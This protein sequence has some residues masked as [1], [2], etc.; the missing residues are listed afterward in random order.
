MIILK[1]AQTVN[2]FYTSWLTFGDIC[3]RIIFGSYALHTDPK[4]EANLVCQ[5][6]CVS[7]WGRDDTWQISE[8]TGSLGTSCFKL[9]R[10]PLLPARCSRS[11]IFSKLCSVSK[12]LHRSVYD[13]LSFI[14]NRKL[15]A[16]L[17]LVC[18]LFIIS[19][20]FCWAEFPWQGK[21]SYI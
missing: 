1:C 13:W 15:T 12:L 10:R 5:S 2:L 9:F 8:S 6:V 21:E 14:S 18:F 19:F 20:R 16:L 4:S 11:V 7:L 3:P 17:C